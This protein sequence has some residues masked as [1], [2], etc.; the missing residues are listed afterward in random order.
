M[1]SHI[2]RQLDELAHSELQPGWIVQTAEEYAYTDP[3]DG[4]V[5]TNQG[6]IVSFTNGSRVVYRLS[7]TGSAGATVRV[8]KEQFVKEWRSS[9]DDSLDKG[10]LMKI[11]L[12]LSNIQEFTGRTEPTVIT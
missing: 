2:R 5:A 9:T 7:G 3:V 6:I 12:E 8:Y 10:P 1:I 11:H 4:S